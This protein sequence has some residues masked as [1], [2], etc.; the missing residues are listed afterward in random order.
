MK[1]KLLTLEELKNGV[2]WWRQKQFRKAKTGRGVPGL[3][4][5]YSDASGKRV[6]RNYELMRRDPNGKK[7]TGNK[8]Y[9]EITRD[10]RTV[11]YV[12]WG[13][14]PE[15]AY[16]F[17][18]GSQMAN[19]RGWT[20]T[21]ARI[22]WNLRLTDGALTAQFIEY[23]N[24]WRRSQKIRPKRFLKGK[25][26]RGVSWRSVEILDRQINGLG[27]LNAS[28]R[29]TASEARK[30]AAIFF[31]EFRRQCKKYAKNAKLESEYGTIANFG[32]PLD[33]LP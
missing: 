18:L 26:N 28:E 2:W 23:I 12:I 10:E 17:A 13:T 7:F 8:N 31:D 22:Q 25:K 20:E 15:T 24:G 32:D 1:N 33:F 11:A 9:L 30:S 21:D 3:P 29:H 6:A 14:P 4:F 5:D 19:E 27:K 16:R